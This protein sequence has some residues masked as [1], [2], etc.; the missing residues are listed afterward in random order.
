MLPF[1]KDEQMLAFLIVGVVA[2]IPVTLLIFTLLT[3]YTAQYLIFCCIVIA[4][5][6]VYSKTKG[7]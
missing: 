7:K 2:Q 5:T 4:C 3:Q 1:G 6:Y